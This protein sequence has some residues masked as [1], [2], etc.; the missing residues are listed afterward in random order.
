MEQ[1]NPSSNIK[2][3]NPPVTTQH[4]LQAERRK[5]S[6]NAAPLEKNLME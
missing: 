2:I 5:F 4:L 6:G 3:P 1:G